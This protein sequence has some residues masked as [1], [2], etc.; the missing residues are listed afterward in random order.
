MKKTTEQLLLMFKKNRLGPARIE[1]ASHLMDGRT[2]I[3]WHVDD[4]N[5]RYVELCDSI[6]SGEVVLVAR[7]GCHGG[8]KVVVYSNHDRIYSWVEQQLKDLATRKS[9]RGRLFS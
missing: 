7:D 8:A 3:I 2:R 9:E 1:N 6:H 4:D 5:D